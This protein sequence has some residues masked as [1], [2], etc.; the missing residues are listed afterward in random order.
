MTRHD[1]HQPHVL[2]WRSRRSCP[3]VFVRLLAR[4]K[5]STQAMRARSALQL[6]Q[7][8]GQIVTPNLFATGPGGIRWRRG[9][10]R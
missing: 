4:L 3:R 10:L 1:P 6:P 7:N 9:P 8:T 5:R 2:A